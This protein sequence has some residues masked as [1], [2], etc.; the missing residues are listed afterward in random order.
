MDCPK[1]GDVRTPTGGA[2][3]TLLKTFLAFT[4]KVRL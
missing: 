1:L 3:F 4:L 2:A